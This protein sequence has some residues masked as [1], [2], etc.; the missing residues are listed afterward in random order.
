MTAEAGYEV[1]ANGRLVSRT[2]R[3][4][5]VRWVYEQAE[6]MAPYLATLQIGRY[7]RTAC[8]APSCSSPRG[9]WQRPSTTSLVSRR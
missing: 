2:P 3:A 1:L 4:G 8:T 7:Q 6:P 5:R 9:C